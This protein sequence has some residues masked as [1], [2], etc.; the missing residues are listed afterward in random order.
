MVVSLTES[1]RMN[2]GGEGWHLLAA[3]Q[4]PILALSQLE[5]SGCVGNCLHNPLTLT[6]PQSRISPITESTSVL[7]SL[8]HS[9][10]SM[11][12]SEVNE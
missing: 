5:L 8:T 1:Q 9:G 7:F 10:C 11:S 4:S 12:I 6:P 2:R 3:Y